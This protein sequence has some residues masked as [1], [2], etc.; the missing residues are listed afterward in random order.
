MNTIQHMYVDGRD[1]SQKSGI[2]FQFAWHSYCSWTWYFHVTKLFH[3]FAVLH[4]FSWWMSNA[5][6]GISVHYVLSHSFFTSPSPFQV[7]IIFSNLLLVFHLGHD[8]Y[9]HSSG[10]LFH[11]VLV[12]SIKVTAGASEGRF[13]GLASVYHALT[14]MP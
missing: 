10:T 11:L 2:S 6:C 12:I 3:F 14:Y 9:C 5:I 8:V 1:K 7:N 13:V 4:E